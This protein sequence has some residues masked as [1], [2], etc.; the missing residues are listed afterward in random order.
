[1]ALSG[2]KSTRELISPPAWELKM[3]FRLELTQWLKLIYDENCEGSCSQSVVSEAEEEKIFWLPKEEIL[4]SLKKERN[5]YF[6]KLREIEIL[7]GKINLDEKINEAFSCIL[8]AKPENKNSIL[9]TSLK[10]LILFV[11][12]QK[13]TFTKE[14][15][16]HSCQNDYQRAQRLSARRLWDYRYKF[17][18][19]DG[20]AIK[21][22]KLAPIFYITLRVGILDN[23]LKNKWKPSNSKLSSITSWHFQGHITS[24]KCEQKNYYAPG[25]L[26]K[27]NQIIY[28][29]IIS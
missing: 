16:T 18:L 25:D 1:M 24:Q 6:S 13:P 15:L 8:Q 20:G 19:L 28:I 21:I 12:L 2:L 10:N 4:D 9:E 14:N 17:W 29:Y 22:R 11:F 3:I 23:F 27:K 7:L 5:F 26:F